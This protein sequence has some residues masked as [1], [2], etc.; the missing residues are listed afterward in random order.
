MKRH[1]DKDVVVGHSQCHLC[2]LCRDDLVEVIMDYMTTTV[3]VL[4]LTLFL[5]VDFLRKEQKMTFQLHISKFEILS[6]SKKINKNI[7]FLSLMW[8]NIL[9]WTEKAMKHFA[10]MDFIEET[11]DF[12]FWN[13]ELGCHFY[14]FLKKSHLYINSIRL[15]C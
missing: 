8:C 3:F 6:F 10:F 5:T 4:I 14:S 12:K 1:Q 7:D 15:L 11:K 2:K 9:F 13:V